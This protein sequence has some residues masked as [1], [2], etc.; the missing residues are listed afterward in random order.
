MES[1]RPPVENSNLTDQ[2]ENTSYIPTQWRDRHLNR[3][4]T[5][6]RGTRK[7]LGVRKPSETSQ[8]KKGTLTTRQSVWTQTVRNRMRQKV[9]E[10][11]T[12]QTYEKGEEKW[13]FISSRINKD[14]GRGSKMSH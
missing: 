14:K 8:T 6:E 10:I 5:D 2:S 4:G 3:D 9:D 12:Y 1:F 7:D 13:S 11:L